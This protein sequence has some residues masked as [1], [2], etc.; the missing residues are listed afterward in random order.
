MNAE[1]SYT[2][3]LRIAAI[4]TGFGSI[5]FG[6]LALGD[7]MKDLPFLS[8]WFAWPVTI[9]F[10]G[11]PIAFIPLGRWGSITAL[12]V[13]ARTHTV[14]AI[15]ALVGWV[16]LQTGSIP[17]AGAPWILNTVAVAAA[18]AAVAW[19][20]AVVW[21]FLVVMA[22][23]GSALRWIDLGRTDLVIPL[24]DG[25]SMLEFSV[26]I[27]ALIIVSLAAGRAQDTALGRAVIDARGAAEAESR[28]RQ[29]TRFGALVHDDVIT[30]LLAAS[31]ATGR[32]PA[33]E[34][35]AER[36][37]ERLDKFVASQT[38]DVPLDAELLEVEVRAAVTE[39]VDG[40]EFEGSFG[41]S[42]GE[43]P[44]AVALAVTDALRE[45]VRNSV[46]HGGADPIRRRLLMG[47][48]VDALS[49]EF[50]DDG[51]GF[52]PARVPESRFGIRTSILDRMSAVGGSADVSSAP[53]RGT[54]VALGW[55]AAP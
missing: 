48:D 17:D 43:F 18:S 23:A 41:D 30:T 55:Q 24:E 29:R 47:G 32:V 20:G 1:S 22:L 44:G 42:P 34:R 35:S 3:H 39:V 31:Q 38:D 2:R 16:P 54:T 40:V 8:P 46:R 50:V 45:A 14:V 27:A 36:A 33:I 26:V 51:V 11:L 52:D 7:I 37:I 28:A 12:R 21:I 4:A 49:V 53:G 6:L 25:L 15:I 13:V 19:R 10:C 9:L 5:V